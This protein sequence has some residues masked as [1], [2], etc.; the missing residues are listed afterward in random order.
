MHPEECCHVSGQWIDSLRAAIE[1]EGKLYDGGFKLGV[2]W[3][4]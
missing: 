3:L 2:K 4:T 1:V